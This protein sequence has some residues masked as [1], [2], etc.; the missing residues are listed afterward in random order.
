MIMR[1]YTFIKNNINYS[2]MNLVMWSLAIK[3]KGNLFFFG[4]R[5]LVI[6]YCSFKMYVNV[7]SAL[8]WKENEVLSFVQNND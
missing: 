4:K 2:Y 7:I 3:V 1:K 6:I 8:Y 5:I